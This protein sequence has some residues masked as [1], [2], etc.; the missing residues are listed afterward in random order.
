MKK[1]TKTNDNV[2]LELLQKHIKIIENPVIDGIDIFVRCNGD[3]DKITLQRKYI[4]NYY[5]PTKDTFDLE[6]FKELLCNSEN[7]NKT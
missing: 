3:I 1:R 2:L 5:M 4:S 6:R 7:T